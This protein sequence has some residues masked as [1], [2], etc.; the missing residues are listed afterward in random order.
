VEKWNGHDITKGIEKT[1]DRLAIVA[2]LVATVAFTAANNVPGSYE[3]GAAVLQRNKLF[4]WFLALDT[5]ALV[6]SVIAVVLLVFGKAS[7]SS[8]SW[9][10]FAVALHCLWASLISMIVAF[11][12]A[13]SAVAATRAVSVFAYIFVY[14]GFM[15]LYYIVKN[16]IAP[17]VSSRTLWKA[18]WR[19]KG[20]NIVFGRR[21]R[22]QYPAAATYALNLVI[23]QA[24]Y[25]LAIVGTLVVSSL[26]EQA[27]REAVRSGA[28]AS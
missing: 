20:R 16:L 4:K 1:S 19:T 9:K 3:Q 11:Y 12:A 18:I 23:F 8:A 22:Q 10:S 17:P 26:S 15:V 5:F 25:V 7:R 27:F 28:P 14:F 13:L 6:S 2:V 24:T 21:I